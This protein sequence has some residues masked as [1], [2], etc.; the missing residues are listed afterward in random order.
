MAMSWVIGCSA[1]GK[2]AVS[3]LAANMWI[4]VI[5]DLWQPCSLLCHWS[6]RKQAHPAAFGWSFLINLNLSVVTVLW[7]ETCRVEGRGLPMKYSWN[8][9]T[10]AWKRQTCTLNGKAGI[11]RQTRP[12][13]SL[14]SIFLYPFVSACLF[15]SPSRLLTVTA[16]DIVTFS[17]TLCLSACLFLTKLFPWP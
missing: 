10:W 12:M 4:L 9:N 16:R 11:S 3:D 7:S 2:K 15:A 8:A 6:V 13:M 5:S 14:H 17:N 1:A